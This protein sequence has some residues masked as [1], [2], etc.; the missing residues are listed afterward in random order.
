MDIKE[1]DIEDDFESFDDSLAREIKNSVGSNQ[2]RQPKK[3]IAED[4]GI[5][6]INKHFINII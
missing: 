3:L 4:Y 5:F 6:S 2:S 1:L